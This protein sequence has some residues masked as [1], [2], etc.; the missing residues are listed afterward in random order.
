MSKAQLNQLCQQR[1]WPA[2]DY[3]HRS[4]GPAH[5]LRFR[6]TVT[7]NGEVY[8]S[9]DD[10]DGFSTAKEAQNLAAKA[11]FER[12]S[13]LPPPPPPQSE[14]QLPY[15][16]Q[17]QVYAQ[18]RHKDLPSYDTIRSG[19]LHAPLFRSTVTID[20]HKFESPQ[21]YHTTK[22]AEF[23]AARVA[24]MSLCQEANPSEQMPAGSASCISLP[25][26]QIN[27]KLQ[28]QMYA[29]KRGKQL[30]WYDRIQEGPS[31]AP[32]FKSIVT[33]DGQTF[34]SP[35]YCHTIKEAEY[36]A[37]NLALVSLAQE[38]QGMQYTNP[39]HELAEKEGS[40]LPVCNTSSDNLKNSSISKSTVH[41][42][43][44]SFQEGPGNTKKQKQMMVAP[45]Q[46]SKDRSQMQQ[47]TETL[48]EQEVKTV[49]SDSSFPQVS[50][51]TSDGQNDSNATEHDSC[52]VGSRIDLPVADK[53]QSLDEPIKSGSM[54]NVKPAA[55]EPSIKA[56]VID[57]TQECRSPPL[58]SVPPT[59]MLNLVA[60]TKPSTE[61]E[62]MDVAEPSAEAEVDVPEPSIKAEGMDVAEPSAEAEVDV[63]E[64]SI[65]D[66]V[67]NSTPEHTSLP[68]GS[69]P[70]TNTSN[71]AAK[72]TAVPVDSARCSYSMSTNRIQIYPCRPDLK[73]PEGATVLPFSDG[74]WV[75]V[76][77]PLP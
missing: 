42:L 41:T 58:V 2:P 37:A 10:G 32:R 69:M 12:L 19:P 44:E 27:H 38:V 70:P 26:I 55:P 14:T 74:K 23:A 59:D 20:G 73:L 60:T 64:P 21:D 22:E 8:H 9:P 11:A 71:L 6:A 24:L 57:L 48:T 77:L 16:S 13:A 43:G 30:P 35:Q 65:E 47:G 18:K 49:E 1:R 15:K 76:S 62:V 17:L 28:L 68:L 29:Q 50:M 56:E 63:P 72:A 54:E 61:A 66:E 25:G 46:P 51:G 45:F 3:T 67:M 4:E 52:S 34:E 53:T 5:S 33:I 36:A 7:V 75:A 39:R 40:S 31:H